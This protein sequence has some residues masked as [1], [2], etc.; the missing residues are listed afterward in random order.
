MRLIINADDLGYSKHRDAGIFDAFKNSAISAASLMVNG[1]TA[2]EAA[3]KAIE[4]GLYLGLHLN[5]TE[6]PSLTGPSSITT[7]ENEMFYKNDFLNLITTDFQKYV[8]A[9]DKETRAQIE[10]FQELTGQFPCHIDGHQHVHI[11][12]GIPDLL[13]PLFQEYGV[14]STRIPDEDVSNC[15]WLDPDRK[16]RYENRFVS[17]LK[18]RLVYKSFD[19]RA[20][21]CFVGLTLMGNDQSSARFVQAISTSFGTIEWM[22][23][24]GTV[25]SSPSVSFS[26]KFDQDRGRE[27]EL[28]TLKGM[29][30][31]LELVDW[32]VFD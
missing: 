8:D 14:K 25:V 29:T 10:R 23:H 12:P 5:L 30:H 31:A 3:H 28:L 11:F 17:C 26:D 21:E 15:E 1:P 4:M 19:V 32:S 7:N 16:K 6:G 13:A 18:G 22:V 2:V 27:H 9:I 24:P 20:P